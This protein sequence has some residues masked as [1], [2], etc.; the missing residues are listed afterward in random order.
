MKKLLL[1]GTSTATKEI[2]DYAKSCGIY[3][4]VT[5]DRDLEVSF[6][7]KWAD[8][9][10]MI[11]TSE[12]EMLANKCR[13]DGVDGVLCGLSEYNIEMMIKLTKK[14]DLPC[15]LTEE[16]WHYSKDKDDFKKKCIEYGVPVAKD[17]YISANYTEEEIA[18]V[19]YPVVVKPIDQNGNRGITYCY[20]KK[21]LIDACK[22][23]RNISNSDKII[24][25]KMLV[26]KEWY[27]YYALAD[28]DIHLLALNGMYA[29]PGQLKNLYS[30]TTTVSDNIENFVNNV[31]PKIKKLLSAIGCREGIAW[32][33]EMLD[34]DG[35][36]Y[37]I[38]MGYR[39][40]GDMT[41]IQYNN[42]IGFNTIK[43]LVDYA[44]GEKH[45]KNELPPEQICAF[46]KCGCSY[47][48]WVSDAGELSSITGVDEVL[49]IP[50]VSYHSNVKTGDSLR[51]YGHVGTFAFVASDIN[52]M[53]EIV[54]SIN[55]NVK[56]VMQDGIDTLIR[57]D[58]FDYI[59]KIYKEG[60]EGK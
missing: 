29:Q 4:I 59:K 57:Y 38:E 45:F 10:W 27:S 22:L 6:A 3:T 32:V 53:C 50:G 56:V 51:K 31:D 49:K 35:N 18:Q 24:V 11:N 55:S 37:I 19:K 42:L 41:F 16:T 14:L 30:L 1:L 60:L 43:W 13:L 15:Y 40:P 54:N 17:Y 12:I 20:N 58:D 26:G 46:K 52:Q 25:E 34:E 7:K 33:Q 2:I 47:N 21:D 48:L 44:L 23:A 8:E 36:F 28:G 5:D 9:Y 39:L